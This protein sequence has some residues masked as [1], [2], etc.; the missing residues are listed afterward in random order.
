[1]SFNRRQFIGASS[2]AGL[3]AACKGVAP[4]SDQR[5]IEKVGLQTYTL[6]DALA[7]DFVGTFEMIKSVGYDYVELNGR[8]FADRSPAELRRILDGTGLPAP[9]THVDYD[10]LANRTSQLGETAA[11]LGCEYVI[12]PWLNDDQRALDDYKTHAEMLNRAA[13]QLAA[14]EVKVGYH[15]HQFEFFDLGEQKTGMDVLLAQT[16]PRLV[17][18]ELDLFWA[19]LAGVDIVSLFQSHP[20]RFRFCHVKDLSGDASD[21]Q[22]SL[23]FETIVK[24]LMAN[25]G[26]GSIPFET[27]FAEN[28]TSG[29]QYFI[30][31]HDMP[32]KPYRASIETS[33][34]AI[35]S[36]RF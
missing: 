2:I 21:W 10:S 5:R 17:H 30:A 33:L 28:E 29:M 20:G 25:V 11:T 18:F 1:M 7:E 3:L 35:R 32:S 15:N 16:D 6:R 13:E 4:L 22:T 27:F 9:L 31:E 8:N 12:L 34:N 24:T 36:M 26:E 14:F 19:S 23:D